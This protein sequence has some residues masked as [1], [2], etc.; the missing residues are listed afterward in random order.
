MVTLNTSAYRSDWIPPRTVI[1]DNVKFDPWP[2]E[3]P[4]NI[5]MWFSPDYELAWETA[6]VIQTDQLLVFNYNQVSGDNFEVFYNEQASDFIVPQ[7]DFSPYD[8]TA[9]RLLGSPEA[10]LTNGQNW[11]KYGIA[12]AG[13]VAP[14]ATTRDGIYGLVCAAGPPR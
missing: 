2:G 14:C 5:G 11:A 7:T 1:V 12:I 13:A 3:D 6:N 9:P 8:S 4:S 10:N